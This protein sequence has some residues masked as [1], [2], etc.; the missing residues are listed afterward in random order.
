[1]SHGNEMASVPQAAGGRSG[2]RQ[3]KVVNLLN[4]HV[5]LIESD[6]FYR[7]YMWLCHSKRGRTLAFETWRW[8]GSGSLFDCRW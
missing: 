6:P 8:N 2:G 5:Q 1:M 4:F 7:E 3:S